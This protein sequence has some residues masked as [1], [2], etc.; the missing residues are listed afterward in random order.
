ME[1]YASSDGGVTGVSSSD[2]RAWKEKRI[3]RMLVDHCLRSGFYDTASLLA[4][5]ADIEVRECVLGAIE[6]FFLESG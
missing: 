2:V 5:E 6:N 3:D 1:E 4:K